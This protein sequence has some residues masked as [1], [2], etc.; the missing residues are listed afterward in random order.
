M[1]VEDKVAQFLNIG[2]YSS[3]TWS[4]EIKSSITPD[5]TILYYIVLTE[6]R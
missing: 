4:F 3:F 5:D 6:V 2:S 1:V